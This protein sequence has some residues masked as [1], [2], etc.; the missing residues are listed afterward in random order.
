MALRVGSFNVRWFPDGQPGKKP[1]GK[2]TDVLWVACQ[3]AEL[4]ASVVAVQEFKTT[5]RARS[6]TK[7]LLAEL[8]RLTKGSWKAFFDECPLESSLHVGMLY[9]STRL[10]L[11]ERRVEASL[12]PLG[13]ACAG[14]LRP[15]LV[16]RFQ[17]KKGQSLEVVSVHLKSGTDRRSFGLRDRTFSAMGRLPRT[18]GVPRVV[19]GDFNTMGCK[20]CQ[21]EISAGAERASR[22]GGLASRGDGFIEP[23]LGCSHVH[24][25]RPEL[26]DGFVVSGP[27]L[28]TAGASVAGACRQT[29]CAKGPVPKE[30]LERVSDHCPLVLDLGTRPSGPPTRLRETSP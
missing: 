17:T 25:S 23:P 6:A 20:D 30:V 24:R 26:L 8:G 1:R 18:P 10:Q 19:A 11:K 13:E 4:D 27:A 16:G 14:S 9:D 29:S 7:R 15:G 2:G 3:I 22:Q 5:E 28:G 12:N 21:P